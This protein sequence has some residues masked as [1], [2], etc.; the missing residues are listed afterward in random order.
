MNLFDYVL[1]YSS[2]LVLIIG[3]LFGLFFFG[4]IDKTRRR[5]LLYLIVSL[6]VDLS[7]RVVL[8][9]TGNNLIFLPLYSAFELLII[10][11]IFHQL[12]T[13][14]MLLVPLVSLG[15]IYITVELI[16]IDSYNVRSFQSYAKIASSFVLVILALQFFIQKLKLDKEISKDIQQLNVAFLV[17]F[18]LNLVLL[19]PINLLINQIATSIIYIWYAYFGATIVFYSYLSYFIW[20]NGKTRKRLPSG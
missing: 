16:Y 5:V 8:I 1:S 2:P 12:G 10:A 14:S 18:A 13:K 4:S 15:L 9:K 11:S 7:S 17:Y 19:L 6:V 3:V 20:K